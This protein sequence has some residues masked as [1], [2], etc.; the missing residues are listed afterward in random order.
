[1]E[2][3]SLVPFLKRVSNNPYHELIQ[4]NFSFRNIRFYSEVVL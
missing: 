4:S 2:P 1:M 3:G